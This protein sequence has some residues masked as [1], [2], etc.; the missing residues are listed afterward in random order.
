[1]ISI[2]IPVY[3]EAENILKQLEEIEKKVSEVKEVL[4]IYDFD[5]DSTLPV[6][7]NNYNSFNDLNILMI[8]N[9][10]AP[11]PSLAH[12]TSARRTER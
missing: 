6:I 4:I 7:K 3:N 11:A 2:V 10:I 8:K 1:M 5:E 9:D 12:S